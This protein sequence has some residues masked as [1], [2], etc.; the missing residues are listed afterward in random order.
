MKNES[1]FTYFKVLIGMATIIAIARPYA[2]AAYQFASAKK[3]LPQ[4]GA[5]LE[6]A[7]NLVKDPAVASL[8]TNT[9]ILP[10][11]WLS[12]FKEVLAPYLNEERQNFLRFLAENSRLSA[13]PA[14]AV[15]FKEYEAQNNKV[16]E[17]QVTTAIPLNIKQQ[18]KLAAKL[19]LSLKHQVT[20]RC[21]VDENILGGA[22]VRAG[23]KVIDGSV[24]GQLTRLLEF[25]IR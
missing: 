25:A 3:E 6:S 11:K 15:M 23:D 4:W 1:A 8:M 22:I 9:R 16:A 18:E 21:E 2:Q 19:T 13:L 17:V 24:R 7:A 10:E 20:L 14:I 5:L 12:L